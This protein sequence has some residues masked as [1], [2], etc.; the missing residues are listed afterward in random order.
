M[1]GPLKVSLHSW[2]VS[3]EGIVACCPMSGD[4]LH[5]RVEYINPS[6]TSFS[7]VN[8]GSEIRV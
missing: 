8:N 7:V 3:I 1:N 2:A 4:L 5:D 6:L